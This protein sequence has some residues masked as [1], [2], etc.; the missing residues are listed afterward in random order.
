[1]D[2]AT[3]YAKWKVDLVTTSGAGGFV[4]VTRPNSPGNAV[5][6]TASE[7]VGYGMLIA[8]YMDEQD[9]FDKLW[10]KPSSYISMRAA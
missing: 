3:A 1:M 4:R 10:K 9:V 2:A 6:S 8:V 7:G 5:N